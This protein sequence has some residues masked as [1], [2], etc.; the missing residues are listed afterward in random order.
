M[1]SVGMSSCSS[2]FDSDKFS[3]PQ[4]EQDLIYRTK[5]RTIFANTV[6]FRSARLNSRP[7]QISG[8]KEFY[9]GKNHQQDDCSAGDNSE[10]D[11]A[12]FQWNV[13]SPSVREWM[14]H[15]CKF[16]ALACRFFADLVELRPSIGLKRYP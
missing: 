2:E 7:S 13:Q 5:Q 3:S 9:L 12:I 4:D 11:A 6:I 8:S 16:P 15:C 1:I 10:I 14:F